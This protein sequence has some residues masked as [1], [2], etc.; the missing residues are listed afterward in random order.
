[1]TLPSWQDKKFGGMIRAALWLETE[2]KL[3]NTFTKAA[4]R[5]AFPEVTQIDRRIRD[6]RDRGWQIDT[7][8][9]DPSLS[10]DE[11]RY[12]KRGA[13]VWISGQA[14]VPEHKSSLSAAQRTRIHQADSY[15]CRACGIG[16][17]ETY[18]DGIE[19]A[20]LNIAR[21]KVLL[22]DGTS[23]VQYVTSCRRCASGASGHEVDLGDLLARIQSLAPLEREVFAGW[24]RNDQRER[25]LMEK[26]WG[27][28]RTLP[29]ESRLAIASAVGAGSEQ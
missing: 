7:S 14:K 5:Q 1:M 22:A 10:Q 17:G 4:L 28:F 13:P 19:Q 26:L 21:R 12:V 16:A 2:V 8:R 18:E 25:S 9:H 23:T 15:L 11:Q 29:E 20:F 27:E 24:V 3:G 6:L